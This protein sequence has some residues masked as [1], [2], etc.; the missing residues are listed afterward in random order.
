[1]K[2]LWIDIV[3]SYLIYLTLFGLTLVFGLPST[4]SYI[5]LCLSFACSVLWFVA[6][7]QLG[8]AFSVMPQG[9]FLVTRGLY[10]KIRHPVYVFGSL[11]FLFGIL[12]VQVWPVLII[13]AVLMLIQIIRVRREERILAESF[14][15]E[16]TVYR[17]KTW[18]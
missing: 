3:A 16:Y 4:L 6:R 17:S 14:G 18:F 5:A 15:A 1:M 10:S 12:A 11:T 13:W 9:R 8:K 7:W 2:L